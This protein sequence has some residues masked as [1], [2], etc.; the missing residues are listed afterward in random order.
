M[1]D[2]QELR[3]RLQ[4]VSGPGPLPGM[5]E[6][7]VRLGRRRR[8]VRRLGAAAT[9]SALA[10]GAVAAVNLL[11]PRWEAAPA[12]P[13]PQPSVAEV[14]P[15]EGAEL[16]VRDDT[17]VSLWTASADDGAAV[18][19]TSLEPPRP[20]A[21]PV[22]AASSAGPAPTTCVVWQLDAGEVRSGSEREL[23]CYAA[24]STDPVPT[25]VLDGLDLSPDRVALRADGS[26]I[27]VSEDDP[28]GNGRVLVAGT[29]RPE[30]YRLQWWA[31][32]AGA[33]APVGPY[34]DSVVDALAFVGDEPRLLVSVT[35]PGD[36]GSGLT[37][38]RI[39]D[40]VQGWAEDPLVVASG[41]LVQDGERLRGV[42]S[43][44]DEAT[45]VALLGPPGEDTAGNRAVLVDPRDGRVLTML[46]GSGGEGNAVAVSGDGEVV[47]ATVADAADGS[48]RHTL[49]SERG[50]TDVTGLP[51]RSVVRVVP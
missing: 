35:R 11:P 3:R 32:S 2:E 22:D 31:S 38:L 36:E 1:T 48:V 24:G 41:A 4:E 51:P 6:L 44:L 14:V 25:A 30:G 5:G 39:D 50:T 7:A 19:R 23:D 10:V 27:A 12:G 15:A 40:P 16:L 45:A 47:V 8:G 17:G 29:S 43:V 18:L 28:D 21:V 13:T 37:T 26:E 42:T 9:T 20:G 46:G 49:T 34:S 33:D